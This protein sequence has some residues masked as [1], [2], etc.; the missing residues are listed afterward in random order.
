[1]YCYFLA[2]MG[3]RGCDRCIELIQRK[4]SRAIFKSTNVAPV[5]MRGSGDNDR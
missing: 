2:G 3:N 1:M 4:W 5:N